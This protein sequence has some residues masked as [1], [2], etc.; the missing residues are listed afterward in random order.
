MRTCS[1]CQTIKPPE[2]YPPR[3]N[4][5]RAC[6]NERSRELY[7]LN[8]DAQR[9]RSRKKEKRDRA[10]AL[11]RR[12]LRRR[13]PGGNAAE[14]AINRRYRL[15]NIYGLTDD[16]YAQLHAAHDGLCAICRRLED[17]VR[18]GRPRAINIDHNHVTGEVRGLLCTPCNRAIWLLNDDPV[19][20]RAAAD[21]LEGT[22]R[23]T[24]ELRSRSSPSPSHTVP[25]IPDAHST[26]EA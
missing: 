3:S 6:K 20:L 23:F 22:R 9:E 14:R 8:L 25:L 16:A 2:A 7:R 13:M 21:Y 4:Q 18:N 5:C 24:P 17:S 15:R 11:A 19:R 12:K 1:K 10:K 26:R